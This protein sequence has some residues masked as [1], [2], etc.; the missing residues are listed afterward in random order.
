MLSSGQAKLPASFFTKPGGPKQDS[1][2]RESPDL[3]S[4]G[5]KSSIATTLLQ[6]NS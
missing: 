5:I 3:V 6:P 4:E 1:T 2:S